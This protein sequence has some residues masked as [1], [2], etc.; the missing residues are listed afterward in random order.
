MRI[1]FVGLCAHYTIGLNYQD[2]Q[3]CKF[4]IERGD[5]VLY[6]SD[7]NEYIDGNLNYVGA[8]NKSIERN[9]KLIRQDYLF[10]SISTIC[11]K[12]KLFKSIYSI[13][14]EFKPDVIYCHGP[15]YINVI[16]IVKYK[17]N[18]KDVTI[19][20]DTHTGYH[21]V[22]IKKWYFT[23][24]YCVYYK[25]LYK[26]LEPHLKKYFYI[27]DSEK[28]FSLKVYKSD[29]NKMEFLP[30]SADE[31]SESLYLKYRKEVRTKLKFNDD[32]I[33]VFH[34]GKI[35]KNKRT[36]W[37]VDSINSINDNRVKLVI[38]GSILN[39]DKDL[40]EKILKSN[41]TFFVGWLNGEELIKFLCAA[42]L[43]CQPGSP[44]ITLQTAICCKTPIIC[45][46]HQFYS[47][48]YDFKSII[49]IEQNMDIANAIKRILL[50]QDELIN[51]KY[52]ASTNSY[53]LDTKYLLK[54][55]MEIL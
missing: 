55:A 45:F 46:K 53:R 30:L 15:Q 5:E 49:W 42:D 21:N 14:D 48:L 36:D 47:Y 10:K 33:M 9:F 28:E 25:S 54:K 1:L 29:M 24:L 41:N 18:N 35:N 4:F 32:D 34:S 3:F 40:E 50:N 11:S 19:Y 16:D 17:K 51:L 37:V 23:L 20:A 39:N 12:L 27:G 44:S 6:I 38:A 8:V 22:N 2:N 13:I 52:Y 31:M 26:Y 7:P 43:Y